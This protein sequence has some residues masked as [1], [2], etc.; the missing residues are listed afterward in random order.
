M[1][2][3]KSR[4][5]TGKEGLV[6]EE[7]EVIRGFTGKGKIKIRGEIWAIQPESPVGPQ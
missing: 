6:G 1:N 7:G 3:H 4:V 2:V 5:T